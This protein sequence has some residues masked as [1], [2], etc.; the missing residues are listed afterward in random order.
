MISINKKIVAD[1]AN[2]IEQRYQVKVTEYEETHPELFKSFLRLQYW[3]D[4]VL[5]DRYFGQNDN[6]QEEGT[7]WQN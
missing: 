4:Q 6:A 3:M 1:L 5:L 2:F 7:Y